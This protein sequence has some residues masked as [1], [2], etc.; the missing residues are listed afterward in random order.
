MRF[1]A[2]VCL[3]LALSVAHARAAIWEWGCQGQMG[4]QQVIFN[5]TSMVVVDTKAKIGDV[6]KL[7]MMSLELPAGS[8][9]H[10][11]YEPLDANGGLEKTIAFARKDD[12][13]H[14]I[15]LTEKSSKQTAHSHKLI[16][17]RDEDTDIYRKVYEFK[18][19][20]EPPRDI[21]MQCFE[22]QLSTRGGRKG[23]D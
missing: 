14:K 1:L 18:R 4:E 17:G 15:T 9:P 3:P 2:C 21:T 10:A 16:C 13:K 11:D 23:C 7:R 5:R 12:D 22:Y 6:R 19:D 8:P 20:D